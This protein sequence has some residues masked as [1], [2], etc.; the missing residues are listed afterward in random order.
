MIRLIDIQC[1]FFFADPSSLP[2]W[3]LYQECQFATFHHKDIQALYRYEDI[4][5]KKPR[6]LPVGTQVT[7]KTVEYDLSFLYSVR[8]Y[9]QVK[10][11]HMAVC[12]LLSKC[13]DSCRW[14]TAATTTLPFSTLSVFP[15]KIFPSLFLSLSLSLSLSLPICVCVCVRACVC[16]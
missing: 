2:F 3:H 12:K 1:A 14:D 16:V 9:R 13:G 5:E 4:L 10:V 8:L 6:R 15:R 7:L 11:G